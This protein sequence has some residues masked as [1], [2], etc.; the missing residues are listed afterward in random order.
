MK[1]LFVIFLLV[2]ALSHAKINREPLNRL[3]QGALEAMET[4]VETSDLFS[5]LTS[6]LGENI[7]CKACHE[8]AK[9]I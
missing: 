6:L 8:I 3:L 1:Y 9:T 2:S 4:Q 7:V 5:N